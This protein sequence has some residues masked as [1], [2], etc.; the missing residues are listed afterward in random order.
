MAR[1]NEMVQSGKVNA[2]VEGTQIEGTITSDGNFRIDGRVMGNVNIKGRLIIGAKGSVEGQ[3]VCNDAEI[4]G[5][6][7]GHIQINNLLSLKSSSKI[8]GDAVFERLKV[9]EGAQLSCTCNIKK[10]LS[11]PV[12]PEPATELVKEVV[13]S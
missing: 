10:A 5:T 8:K 11:N 7:D 1:N 6:F 2:I 3:V 12:A 9:E 13:N 4:E